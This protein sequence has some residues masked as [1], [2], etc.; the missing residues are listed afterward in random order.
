MM[1]LLL[2]IFCVARLDLIGLHR[3]EFCQLVVLGWVWC[4]A[5]AV[6]FMVIDCMLGLG[7]VPVADLV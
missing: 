7:S 5:F 1:C 2:T 4:F 3:F 6:C